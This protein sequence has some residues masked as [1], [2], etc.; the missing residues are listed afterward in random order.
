MLPGLFITGTDTNVGKSWVTAAIAGCLR[1]N[2]HRPGVIKPVATGLTDI[3]SEETDAVTLLRHA[4]WP[5]N[6][7]MLKICCPVTFEAAAAPTVA[8]RA[9]GRR[10]EWAEVLAG[11]QASLAG[12]AEQGAD[13]IL[14][15]GVGGLECPLAEGG[16][17]VADLL[18][19]LDFPTLVVARRGLGTLS[20]TISAVQRLQ[21]GSARVAGVILNHV[22]A[23]DL[24]GIPEST[25]A[26]ELSGRIGTVGLLHDG[27]PAENP[28]KL[29]KQI[30]FIGWEGRLLT[31]RFQANYISA[32]G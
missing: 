20:H 4:G 7:A 16:K 17:T 29:S 19:L 18:E 9:E 24:H 2:G 23:D 5:V 15:E 28:L 30:A 12:W 22:P 11:V 26:L 3:F 21:R 27:R 8:A 1:Q 6:E 32:Q 25:A 10:L 14:V 31:S 13:L